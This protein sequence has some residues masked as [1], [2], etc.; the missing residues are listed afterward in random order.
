MVNC[1][2][3]RAWLKHYPYSIVWALACRVAAAEA[4]VVDVRTYIHES[5][6]GPLVR[7]KHG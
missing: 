4:R 3:W 1:S 5:S 6:R 7:A 2:G